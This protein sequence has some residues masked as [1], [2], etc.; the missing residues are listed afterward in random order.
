MGVGGIQV[1]GGVAMMVAPVEESAGGG[2][3]DGVELVLKESLISSGSL[4]QSARVCS[5]MSDSGDPEALGGVG[6]D[7]VSAEILRKL[8]CERWEGST[9]VR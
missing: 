1:V 7:G 6:R 2:A 4:D 9:Y 8:K 3:P 5:E